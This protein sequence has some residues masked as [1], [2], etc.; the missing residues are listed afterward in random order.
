MKNFEKGLIITEKEAYICKKCGRRAIETTNG[1]EGDKKAT[2]V[3]CWNCD[4]IEKGNHIADYGIR[5]YIK[6]LPER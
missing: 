2:F 6:R 5:Q 3:E 4:I 1:E